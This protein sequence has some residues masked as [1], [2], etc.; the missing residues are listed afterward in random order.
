MRKV[1][2]LMLAVSLAAGLMAGCSSQTPSAPGGGQSQGSS[3]AGAESG[4]GESAKT[5][6]GAESGGTLKNR[7]NTECIHTMLNFD[8]TGAGAD[9]Y[10]SWPVYES[11]FKPNAEGTVDPW[12]LEDYS[13]DPEEL[14]YTFYVRKGV[15]FFGWDG[16]GCRSS[17]MES[18]SLSGSRRQGG[19][20]CFPQS[21][22]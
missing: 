11:L 21:T 10:Y 4:N 12:L 15:T 18:G 8:L 13:Y 22:P 2:A 1:I 5:D 7:I 20:F 9:Y 16:S 6:A 3:A 17:E 14:T 19:S